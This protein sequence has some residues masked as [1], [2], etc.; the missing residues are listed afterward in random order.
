[1]YELDVN[2]VIRGNNVFP[3]DIRLKTNIITIENALSRILNLRGVNF[4]WKKPSNQWNQL[5]I[6]VIAQEVE[7]VFPEAVMTDKAGYKAVSYDKLVAPLIEAVKE[8]KAE[9]DELKNRNNDLER[10]IEALENK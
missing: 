2:G 7:K 8:L 1:M 10:R 9:N 6:G 5:N 4:N 3:S